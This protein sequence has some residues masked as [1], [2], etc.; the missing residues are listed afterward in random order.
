MPWAEC[1]LPLRGAL[2]TIIAKVIFRL[3]LLRKFFYLYL[4]RKLFFTFIYCESYFL[5]LFIAEAI[6]YLYLLRKLFFTFLPFYFF[7][8]KGYHF[9][10]GIVLAKLPH[11]TGCW[12]SPDIRLT[13]VCT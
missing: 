10:T 2:H 8:F 12:R 7:T 3:Y 13:P 5:P 6:F 1:L 4:L 11:I 9:I